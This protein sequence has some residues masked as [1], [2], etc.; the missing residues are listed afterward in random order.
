MNAP[1]QTFNA[2]EQR[3]ADWLARA[4]GDMDTKAQAEFDRWL[5]ADPRHQEAVDAIQAVWTAFDRPAATA[6]AATV[7]GS[8]ALGARLQVLERRARHRRMA[9]GAALAM[10]ACLT[11]FFWLARPMGGNP[12]VLFD[13]VVASARISAPVSQTLPDGSVVEFKPGALIT[14]DFRPDE[15]RVILER[16]EAHFSVTKNPQRPFIV[17]A[18]T[19]NVRAVGTAFAVQLGSAEVEVFV[20]EGKVN[21]ASLR[22]VADGDLPK[23]PGGTLSEVAPEASLPVEAGQQATVK[24]NAGGALPVVASMPG[25]AFAGRL[26]WRIPVLEFSETTLA[27]AVNLFN[28]YSKV[29]LRTGD[30]E[31]AGMRVTGVFRSDNPEGFVSALEA[32]LGLRIERPNGEIL[33]RRP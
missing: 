12:E 21:V 23:S 8:A 17:K 26:S 4:D 19:V 6:G 5:A 27:E 3:A 16:G 31:V 13:G 20:T 11:V 33:L 15:R 28:R 2:I 32:T 7:A 14:V 24:L 25:G 22:S 30:K 18:G 10:A 9:V 29:R 1:R